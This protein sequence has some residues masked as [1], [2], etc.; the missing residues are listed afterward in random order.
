[1]ANIE[2]DPQGTCD[3]C[4]QWHFH[5]YCENCTDNLKEYEVMRRLH[6][7]ATIAATYNTVNILE[8]RRAT[9]SVISIIEAQQE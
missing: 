9:K 2:Q 4:G 1:V 3:I 7:L 8:V 5:N 6:A